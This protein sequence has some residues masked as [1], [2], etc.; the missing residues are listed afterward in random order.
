MFSA[1]ILCLV[2]TGVMVICLRL[3][4]RPWWCKCRRL[5]PWATG[6]DCYSQHLFDPWTVSHIGHGICVYGAFRGFL[7]GYPVS[8]AIALTLA[9]E[10]IWEVLENTT[11]VISTYRRAGDKAYFGDSITNSCG[12]VLACAA[13][14]LFTSLFV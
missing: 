10:I 9:T 1:T 5:R 2:C 4:G 14:A 8:L 13:G 6:A 7:V 11:F 3:M 12:D